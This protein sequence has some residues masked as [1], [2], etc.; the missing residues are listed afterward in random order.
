MRDKS[1]TC[2]VGLLIRSIFR[3]E[4]CTR[5]EALVR[6]FPRKMDQQDLFCYII[7]YAI[8]QSQTTQRFTQTILCC[9][10]F[11]RVLCDKKKYLWKA[12]IIDCLHGW[13]QHLRHHIG[14]QKWW[15]I[16][17]ITTGH[18]LY[19]ALGKWEVERREKYDVGVSCLRKQNVCLRGIHMK[20]LGR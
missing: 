15:F 3:W 6:F 16:S 14:E 7:S 5:T 1:K 9:H 2:I 18:T 19:C 12:T 20:L 8:T 17:V 11:S 10:T 4:N 13:S